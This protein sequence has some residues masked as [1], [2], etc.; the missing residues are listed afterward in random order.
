MY[1]RNGFKNPD[2]NLVRMMK[3]HDCITSK[4]DTYVSAPDQLGQ[5]TKD[6]YGNRQRV[7]KEYT[8]VKFHQKNIELMAPDEHPNLI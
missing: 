4:L 1:I 6:H 7:G 5:F 8:D 3:N 2:R